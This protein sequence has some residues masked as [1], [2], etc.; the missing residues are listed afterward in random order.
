MPI[1]RPPKRVPGSGRFTEPVARI[2]VCA[3]ISVPSK[4]PPTF[5]L[6]SSVTTPWPSMTSI[7]FF[8]ISPAT[9]PVSVLTTLSRRAPTA[10]KSTVGSPTVMPKSPASRISPSTSATRSTALA[11]M[12]A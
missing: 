11:G 6:P 9:P 8:F 5:T 1:T 7:P 3:A 2:T 12:Q 4:L 10:A